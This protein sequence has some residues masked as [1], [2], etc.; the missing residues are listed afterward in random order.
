MAAIETEQMTAV[1]NLEEQF[2]PGDDADA[3]QD[4]MFAQRISWLK[5]FRLLDAD[6]GSAAAFREALDGS[7]A[8]D[9]AVFTSIEQLVTFL[10][11]FLKCWPRKLFLKYLMCVMLCR[12]V[13]WCMRCS[14]AV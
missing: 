12:C 1:A 3:V 11:E 6:V 8:S 5:E 10:R 13:R 2:S 7:P 14:P 9:D 4:A